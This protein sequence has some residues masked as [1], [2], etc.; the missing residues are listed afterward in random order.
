MPPTR[1]PFRLRGAGGYEGKKRKKKN[2]RRRRPLRVHPAKKTFSLYW[3]NVLVWAPARISRGMKNIQSRRAKASTARRK[4]QR[5]FKGTAILPGPSR[6][7]RGCSALGLGLDGQSAASL[8]PSARR[9]V[10]VHHLPSSSSRIPKSKPAQSMRRCSHTALPRFTSLLL[11]P[12]SQSLQV[13]VAHH[14]TD[15]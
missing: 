4:Q 12:H 15:Q 6:A 9:D 13:P 8:A 5:R 11:V 10:S 3:L 7:C 1:S 2:Q 14:R